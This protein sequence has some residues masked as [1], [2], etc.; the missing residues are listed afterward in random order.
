MPRVAK[1]AYRWKYIADATPGAEEIPD[2]VCTGHIL[3]AG[4]D[5]GFTV[6]ELTGFANAL[7]AAWTDEAGDL[8]ALR[9]Y[10]TPFTVLEDIHV[11]NVVPDDGHEVT[12][13]GE[14]VAGTFESLQTPP[15]TCRLIGL[16]TGGPDRR[17]RGRLYFPAAP[18]AVVN[19]QAVGSLTVV[20]C[21]D[22]GAAG[23]RLA[24]AIALEGP[25]GVAAVLAVFSRTNGIAYPVT[26]FSIDEHLATQRRREVWPR[27][28][29]DYT[30]AG[31]FVGD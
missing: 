20:G 19:R 28:R 30:L 13:D 3:G 24:Q 22:L 26:S 16:R 27:L 15:Q 8:L 25:V 6:G 4:S 10:C 29:R 17:G 14:L 18:H 9:H 23:A 2:V 7:F 1:F 12:R 5:D 31:E 11:E 21:D